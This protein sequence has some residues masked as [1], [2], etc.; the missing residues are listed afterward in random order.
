MLKNID[1]ISKN[2]IVFEKF[3]VNTFDNIIYELFNREN[4]VNFTDLNEFWTIFD[5]EK[6]CEQCLWFASVMNYI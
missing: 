2:F 1:I 6:Q 3:L 5:K 4:V